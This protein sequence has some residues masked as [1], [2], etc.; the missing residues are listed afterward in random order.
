MVIQIHGQGTFWSIMEKG[1]WLSS[2]DTGEDC[3]WVNA[4]WEQ[5]GNFSL[6]MQFSI[7]FK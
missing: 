3:A 2:S 4:Q 7:L 1:S 5:E 6:K